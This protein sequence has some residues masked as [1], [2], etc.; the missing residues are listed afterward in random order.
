MEKTRRN[1]NSRFLSSENPE[2]LLKDI[3]FCPKCYFSI[4]PSIQKL[5]KNMIIIQNLFN[6]LPI[7][8]YRSLKLMLRLS[9]EMSFFSLEIFSYFC[10]IILSILLLRFYNNKEKIENFGFENLKEFSI[11]MIGS[12]IFVVF[13]IIFPSASFIFQISKLAGVFIGIILGTPIYVLLIFC[14]NQLSALKRV[15]L[16]LKVRE[17]QPDFEKEEIDGINEDSG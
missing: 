13:S 12:N 1:L 17:L 2:D 9:D 5:I 10:I 8:L 3:G 11:L 6:C 14:V 4:T 7:L 16:F 15:Q